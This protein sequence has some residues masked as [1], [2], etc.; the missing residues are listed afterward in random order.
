MKK[1]KDMETETKT[2][3]AAL[4]VILTLVSAAVLL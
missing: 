2:A 4:L 1:F 3:I